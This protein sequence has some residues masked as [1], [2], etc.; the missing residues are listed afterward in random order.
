MT[1]ELYWMNDTYRREK[2]IMKYFIPLKR[3]MK[4]R[5]TFA[6]TTL[7]NSWRHKVKFG[8]KIHKL[9]G[10]KCAIQLKMIRFYL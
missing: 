2:A 3:N 5:E 7:L 6:T 1:Q 8:M 9:M 4:C 10:Q